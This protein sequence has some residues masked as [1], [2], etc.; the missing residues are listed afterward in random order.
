MKKNRVEQRKLPTVKWKSNWSSMKLW[1][2]EKN[3]TG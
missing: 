1:E 2:N 3:H